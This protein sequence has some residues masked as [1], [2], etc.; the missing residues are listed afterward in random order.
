MNYNL[1]VISVV[2]VAFNAVT[3]IEKT[4]L[5]VINQTYPN[6]EYIIIDGGSKDGTVDII[7]KYEDKIA[8]WVS[9]P[10][11]GIY[12]AM[13]K[14]IRVATGE[15]INFMNCGDSFYQDSV[16]SEIFFNRQY[17]KSA[18]DVIYG[19][20]SVIEEWGIYE[21]RPQELSLM[22]RW[23]PFCHQ[24]SFVKISLMKK[25]LFDIQYSICA[26]H[27]FFYII[28]KT[29]SFFLYVP[30]TIANFN[31]SIYSLSSNNKALQ[32]YENLLVSKSSYIW[33]KRIKFIIGHWLDR[34]L[35]CLLPYPCIVWKQRFHIEHNSYTKSI[36][37]KK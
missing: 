9:E 31:N 35:A 28:W 12:D 30:L 20:T 15:W 8:Y 17:I 6:I 13:N 4:I 26:D 33:L 25:Y 29:K 10:D 16:L 24:S 14:G 34:F 27:N 19:D 1:P 32:F 23:L 22:K 7:K 36:S 3:T 21:K 11:K 18:P 5:S 37:W 2:T